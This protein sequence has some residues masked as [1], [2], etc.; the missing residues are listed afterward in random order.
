MSLDGHI[1]CTWKLITCN[2]ISSVYEIMSSALPVVAVLDNQFIGVPYEITL[3]THAHT[4]IHTH[5][6]TRSHTHTHTHTSHIHQHPHMIAPTRTTEQEVFGVS[7]T[8]VCFGCENN[9]DI[10]L[11]KLKNVDAV[12][13]WHHLQLDERCVHACVWND[14]RVYAHVCTETLWC[15]CK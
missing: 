12:L 4:R 11:D 10:P 13:A 15:L 5:M 9:K 1:W 7:A 8:V 2:F 6:Q 3:G 14:V